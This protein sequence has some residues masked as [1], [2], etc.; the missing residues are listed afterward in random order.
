M[1]SQFD[2]CTI[3]SGERDEDTNLVGLKA[4]VPLTDDELDVESFGDIDSFQALGVTSVPY[5]R[6]QFGHCEGVVLRGCGNT[7]GVIVGA[8]DERCAD[9]YASLAEGDTCLHSCDP[10]A[11]AQ[12]QA[13][14]NKQVV[15]YTTD[16][17]GKTITLALDGKNNKV[18]LAIG[19]G[20]L[21]FNVDDERVSIVAPGGKSSIVLEGDKIML[22]GTVVLG[23]AVPVASVASWVSGGAPSTPG[24]TPFNPAPNVFVG[25]I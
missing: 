7:D 16:K 15:L 2:I 19:G 12:V 10:N 21:E 22:I 11:V 8:R 20:L 4:Y 24:A 5:P 13:K 17:N 18:Q 3:A 25:A 14:A 6:D 23:S 9:V 1:P